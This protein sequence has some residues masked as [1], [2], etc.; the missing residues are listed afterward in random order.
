MM[1]DDA[2]ANWG[3]RNNILDPFHNKVSIGI[4]YD[5]D[6]FYMVQDFEDDYVQWTN[7]SISQ[8]EAT[9]AGTLSTSETT[10]RQVDIYFDP[11]KNLTSND[12]TNALYNNS[13]DAGTFVGSVANS[14]LLLM[15]GI[16]E[17]AKSWNQSGE[18]FQLGFS[19]N[20]MFSRYG[21]GIYT[22]RLWS[23]NG[24]CLTNYSVFFPD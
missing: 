8:G 14:E 6:S 5:N 10:I 17:P 4:A 11:C 13:Y 19:L 20:P 21:R 2:E 23:S 15:E 24:E 7:L 16:F 3:H 12:L 1:N 22:L 18:A 9:M